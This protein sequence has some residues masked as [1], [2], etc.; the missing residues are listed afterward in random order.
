MELKQIVDISKSLANSTR[1]N[2][3]EWLKDPEQHFPPHP[4]IGHFNFGVCGT[5]IQQKTEMSQSTISTYLVNMEKCG[6]LIA[7]RKGKWTY[8]K[9]NET[10]IS[11]YIESLKL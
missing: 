3:L 2:I 1:V 7:T 10:T 6:L 8:F 4:T 11:D 5:F 9:R